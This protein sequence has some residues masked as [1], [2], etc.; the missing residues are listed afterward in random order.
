MGRHSGYIAMNASLAH[1]GVDFCLIPELPF[2]L[3][4]KNGLF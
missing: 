4:G 3:S 2:E 1:A